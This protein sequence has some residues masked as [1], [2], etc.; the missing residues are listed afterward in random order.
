MLAALHAL[1]VAQERGYWTHTAEAGATGLE[2]RVDVLWESSTDGKPNELLRL[3]GRFKIRGRHEAVTG[4]GL[5]DTG[6]SR[7]FMSRKLAE[8]LGLPIKPCPW[9]LKVSNGDGT[10]QLVQGVVST[11][12]ALGDRFSDTF[13]FYVID[14]ARYDFIIG[15]PDIRHH[16]MELSGDPL[17]I[18]VRGAKGRSQ[19]AVE[20]PLILSHN[21][22]DDGEATIHTLYCKKDFDRMS[23]TILCSLSFQIPMGRALRLCLGRGVSR[24]R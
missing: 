14:L 8:H 1:E 5:Y 11:K 20:L 2:R 12:M 6:A 19:G 15:L 24:R 18:K 4:S 3:P 21:L 13:E 7:T 17:R 23:G 22:E 9:A 16:R 10:F